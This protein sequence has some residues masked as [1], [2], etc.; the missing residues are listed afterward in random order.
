MFWFGR[1][2]E[3]CTGYVCV[4]GI[5]FEYVAL[6][7]GVVIRMLDGGGVRDRKSATKINRDFWVL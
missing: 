6:V 1:G 7:V 2:F 5:G 4:L 3:V